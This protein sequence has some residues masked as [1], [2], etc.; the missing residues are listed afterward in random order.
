MGKDIGDQGFYTL[1]IKK[2]LFP[3]LHIIPGFE[4]LGQCFLYDVCQEWQG[5]MTVN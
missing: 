2:L 5:K 3:D 1:S 4:D